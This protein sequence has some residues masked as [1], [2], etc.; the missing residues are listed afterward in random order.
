MP[1][2]AA[3]ATIEQR[4]MGA[5]REDARRTAG[6]Q[7]A[8]FEAAGWAIASEAWASSTIAAMV[9]GATSSLPVAG[10]GTL[11]VTFR[12]ERDADLPSRLS[13]RLEDA[14]AGSP[15]SAFT[16]RVI[17]I[18]VVA[19]ILVVAFALLANSYGGPAPTPVAIVL[20]S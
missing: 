8:A 5:S 11:V 14:D 9:P 16:I 20:P 17:V 15:L 18:L 13:A 1:A 2:F 7:L 12:A 4:Y 6:P 10:G 3:G 19:A